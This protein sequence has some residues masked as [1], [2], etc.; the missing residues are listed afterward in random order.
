MEV[1]FRERLFADDT[2]TT[3]ALPVERNGK[4]KGEGWELLLPPPRG[5]AGHYQRG[6]RVLD[7][8][9]LERLLWY[10]EAVAE[11]AW[12]ME[13]CAG[14]GGVLMPSLEPVECAFWALKFE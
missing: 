2:T 7:L 4:G 13:L 1:A 3:E 5:A 14:G 8:A 10:G 6:R 12:F 9:G 11:L